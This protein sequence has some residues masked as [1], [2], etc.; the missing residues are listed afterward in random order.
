MPEARRRSIS[1]ASIVITGR[2]SSR[3]PWP[4]IYRQDGERRHGIDAA[5]A[6]YNRLLQAYPR[7]GYEVVILPKA[8]VEERADFLLGLLDNSPAE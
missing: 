8:P 7:L 5:V 3:P 1:S 6:E 4:E 2:S